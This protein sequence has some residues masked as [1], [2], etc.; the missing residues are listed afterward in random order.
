MGSALVRV[1]FRRLFNEERFR[2]DYFGALTADVQ[3]HV[4][5]EL[6]VPSLYSAGAAGQ[7]LLETVEEGELF[8]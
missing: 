1:V 7:I 5:R 4:P 2:V 8:R 3:E 6:R